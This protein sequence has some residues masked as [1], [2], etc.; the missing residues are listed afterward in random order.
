MKSVK[1]NYFMQIFPFQPRCFD[2]VRA[3]VEKS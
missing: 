2:A 1:E 3:I